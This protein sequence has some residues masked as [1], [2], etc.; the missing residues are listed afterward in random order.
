MKTK[1][2][3]ASICCLGLFMLLINSCHDDLEDSTFFTTDEM[4]IAQ[5]LVSNPEKFS[6][7][8]EILE[9]T[10]YYNSLK[11][12]GSYTCLAPTNEAVLPFL[13][14]TFNVSTVA[15]VTSEDQIEYLKTI[16]KFHTLPTRRATSSFVEG[17]VADTTYTGDFLTTSFL[18]GGGI[19]NIKINREVGLDQYDIDADNGIIHAVDGV[20]SPF[21]DPVTLVME[22]AGQHSIFIEALKQ[23]GY[24]DDFSVIFNADG[25]KNNF[26]IL[27]ESD[28]IYSENGINSFADLVSVISPDDSNYMDAN[29]NL[30]RFIAY[31][32][33][34]TFLYSADFPVDG[35]ISTVLPKNAIKSLK[36]DKELRINETETGT[37][38]TWTSLISDYS[39]IPAKNGVYHTVDKLLTIFI[40]KAKKVIF[41]FGTDLL[42]FKSGQIGFR[43]WNPTDDFKSFRVF[44]STRVRILNNGAHAYDRKSVLNLGGVTWLEWDTPVLP[45]GKYEVRV[46]GNQGNNG[47]PILQAYWDGEP[48][49]SQWDMR[50]HPG[51]MGIFG[52]SLAMRERGYV[53]G[54]SVDEYAAASP[55]SAETA[56][57]SRFIVTEELLC[58]EQQSHVFRFETIRSGGIP[59][60][61]VEF[62]PVD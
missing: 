37:N 52:D 15:E 43:D 40:P 61:Y 11:S 32:A 30:N 28:D 35:F 56:G 23:T 42:E 5:T 45:K 17:R 27:A 51:E 3:F 62:V 60:D 33:T 10:E 7:Y 22:N 9:K 21:V 54:V 39:N 1:K 29:N 57:W 16:V 55:T 48:I 20:L 19:A 34:G 13:Q 18:A 53:R 47:R 4:S 59:I 2:L 25:V 41:D 24:Y 8:V 36:T 12:Y 50:T 38:D 6:M 49:G 26:T 44:P 46:C 31:H 14:E 58:P